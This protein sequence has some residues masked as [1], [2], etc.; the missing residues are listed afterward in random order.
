[1]TSRFSPLLKTLLYIFFSLFV[2]FTSLYSQTHDTLSTQTGKKRSHRHARAAEARAKIFQELERTR[3]KKEISVIDTV[4]PVQIDSSARLEQFLYVRRDKPYVDPQMQKTHPLFLPDPPIV[5]YREELD[6][7]QWVY[8]LRRV[9]GDVDVRI[10]IDV[11]LEIYT[12]LRFNRTKRK[13]WEELVQPRL[14]SEQKTG[15][16]EVMGKITNI[17]IPVPKNPLFSIFGPNIIRLQINGGVDIHAAFRNTKSDRFTASPLGQSR[18]EPDFK[19]EVQVTVKGEIGDKLKISADWNTQRTFEYENQLRVQYTGY[20]DEI[21]QSVEAGNV[22]LQTG[23]SLIPAS[24]AL[25]GIKAAFQ[26][27]PL[28]LTTIA[29]QKK[30]QVKELTA[31]GGA[32]AQQ[33]TIKP[34]EYSRNHFFIDTV[35]ERYY[36]DNFYHSPRIAHPELKIEDIEVWV[37]RTTMS[38]DPSK[39]RKIIAYMSIDSIL[40]YTADSLRR[41]PES[42]NINSVEGEVEVGSFIQ[43]TP[44]IDFDVDYEAGILSLKTQVQPDQAIVVAYTVQGKDIGTFGSKTLRDGRYLVMKL[45]KPRRLDTDPK[46]MPTAWRLLLKNRYP[47]GGGGLRKENF[48]LTLQYELPGQSPV[49]SVLPQNVNLL[50]LFGLDRYAGEVAGHD[51]A[52]DYIPNY[53]VDEARGEIIF[54][55]L[56]PFSS[57]WIQKNLAALNAEYGWGLS[58]TDIKR[59]ADSLSFDL[60]YDTTH[61]GA[62]RNEKN[63]YTMTGTASSSVKSRYELGFNVVEGSVQVLVDGQLATPNVDYTVDYITGTVTI[64]NTS[65]LVPGRNVQIKYE[66]NDLF[67]LASKTL[68]GARGEL[69]LGKNAGLGFTIMNLNQQSLSDKI[70]LGEEP[71][72]NTIFGFDGG[73]NLELPSLTNA[74]NY[75]PGIRTTEKSTLSLKGEYAHIVPNPN[76]R[77]SPLSQDG[78]KGV[79]YI[80]DFE[81]ALQTIPISVAYTAWHE[82][83]PPFYHPFLDMYPDGYTIPTIMDTRFVHDS[84]KM[85]YKARIGWFNILQSDVLVSEIWGNRKSVARG[86]EQVPVLNVYFNPRERGAFNYSFDL[87]NILQ[88]EP[89]RTWGG[90]QTV[91]G[92]MSTN[93]IDQNISFIEL[94]IKVIKG[95][96]TAKLYLDLGYISED[97]LANG[98]LNTEDG[99]DNVSKLPNGILNPTLEDVGLDELRDSEERIR[100]RAFLDHYKSI[101]PE[102]ESDPSGDNWKQPP[103]ALTRPLSTDVARQFLGCN[104]TEGNSGSEY[105]SRYPDT[106]DL[107]GNNNLDRFNAYFEYEIPLD[108]TAV[109]FKRLVSG[110]GEKGWYL[111]RIPL[112]EFKRQIGSPSFTNVEGVRLWVTGASNELLFRIAEFNL[113]GNQWEKKVR[114]DPNFEVSVVNYEDNPDYARANPVPRQRDRTQ[115]TEEIYNNEQSLNLIVRNLRDGESKEAVKYLY[116]KLD[117]FNYRT[118][119]MMVHGEEGTNTIKGY[120]E[121][122]YIN[123]TNYDAEFYFRFGA[124]STNYY[125]YRAPLRPGWSQNEVIIRFADLTALKALQDTLKYVWGYVPNGI[126]GAKYIIRGTPSLR[127]VKYFVLGIEN[128]HGIGDTVLNGEVW[129]NEMRLAD[130]DDTPGS[131]YRFDTQLKLAD[132]ASFGFTMNRTDPYF[133]ELE[134]SF[135]SREET[136]SWSFSSSFNFEKFLPESWSGTSLPFSYSHSESYS[137]PLYL[138]GSDVLVEEAAKQLGQSGTRSTSYANANDVRTRSQVLNV[139][140]SYSFP[141]IRLNIPVDLWIIKKTINQ[142]TF[143]YS[144]SSM[145]RRS[146]TTEWGRSWN[147]SAQIRYGIQFDPTN[148]IRPFQPLNIWTEL[149]IYY[150]PRNVSVSA[151]VT[152]SRSQDKTRDQTN[153]NQPT[154]DMTAQRSLS[155][156][157]QYFEGYVFSLGMDYQVTISS[158]LRHLLL[159]RYGR[160]RSFTDIASML[161]MSDRLLSFGLD[162]QYSQSINFPMKITLPREWEVSKIFTPSIQYGS[163]YQWMY[164]IQAGN[165]GKSAGWNTNPSFNLDINLR[166]IRDALWSSS[167]MKQQT[168]PTDTTGKKRSTLT[169]QLDAL[170]RLLF[171]TTFFDFESF[172]FSFSQSNTA[173]HNG[174]YGGPGFGNLFGRVPFVHSASVQRGPSMWYQL[175]LSSDPNG[176]VIVKTKRSFPFI[177][178]YTVPGLR[179]PKGSLTDNYTQNNTLTLRTGRPLF[180]G[181]RLDLNWKYSWSYSRNRS[182][183]SDSLGRVTLLSKIVSGDIERSFLTVPPVFVFKFFGT[184]MDKVNERFKELKND[185]GDRRSDDKKM[186]QAFEEGME[187]FP[188]VSK[189]FGMMLPRLNW[190]FRWTGLERFVLFRSF[191]AGVSLE[192]NYISSYKERWRIT[193]SN[194]RVTESQSINYGFSPLVGVSITFKKMGTGSLNANVRYNTNT[195]YDLSPSQQNVSEN[196]QSDISV[197][198]TYT[199]RGFEFPLFGISLSNDLDASFTYSYSTTLRS[200]YDFRTYKS[201]GIPQDGI[202]RT[203]LEPRLRYVLSA[204]VTGSV[205][206]RYTKTEPAASGSRIPGTT[207]NEGGLDIHIAIQ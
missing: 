40:Y 115:A 175:G 169:E 25:F 31:S 126:E 97:A 23:T 49:T 75:L 2:L 90:M 106:E 71:L 181:M 188:L 197:S 184:G 18:S 68:L 5:K 42:V 153:A 51:N 17:E 101:F 50:T 87:R 164:N 162:Y 147:W 167:P 45:V 61:T 204:R 36:E 86:Q 203:T 103:Y 7:T 33:F 53:T 63:R 171:K 172:S 157:W 41:P 58:T 128:P 200:L 205:Y 182:V 123:A 37:M 130:V 3:E 166:P 110:G 83:S 158:T 82:P 98:S 141:N 43:L 52:F 16:A 190:T 113:V 15:L 136:Q 56:K 104:G 84:V 24:Q 178:G 76:T 195:V 13:I 28:R 21:V 64:K 66:A 142:I 22:S 105:G 201:G 131:A 47:V 95:E 67:Q 77:S 127:D 121:F 70:R 39:E 12:E 14:S 146:P 9:V 143:S 173:Q 94:W 89:H 124:D 170:S 74:L 81:G 26:F 32:T 4:K 206:Y 168:T 6:S 109:E 35:Y 69:D 116:R 165:L 112:D 152:R 78:G 177:T 134:K 148:Y 192:H 91:L 38:V 73:F 10:P 118:L 138:P 100:W 193:T 144:Y 156:S 93:L 60:M 80:D 72:S 129:V 19:Q 155:F 27:G 99:L 145:Y 30:G 96:S 54:P 186:S 29:T 46:K 198:V 85:A 108:T 207:T 183:M 189:L 79:A 122:K 161:I 55:V 92:T 151:S 137:K 140:E 163:R 191:A 59:Y 160:E 34:H 117:I 154:R 185:R 176:T 62:A 194:E 139:T 199:Q 120:K 1:M 65:Y 132:F 114:D 107:N 149:K 135:G 187:A 111:L 133:H 20:E 159:D 8:R 150:T 44:K 102:F 179:A 125:E 48:S 174:I 57:E 202:N 180:E 196:A 88:N 11:P 119:K